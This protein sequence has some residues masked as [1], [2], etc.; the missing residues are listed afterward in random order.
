[1]MEEFGVAYG[2]ENNNEARFSRKK[3]L[4]K[5]TNIQSTINVK[6]L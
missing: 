4:Y 6:N 2:R 5:Q 3:N 1:M